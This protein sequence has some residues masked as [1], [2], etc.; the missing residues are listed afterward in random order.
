MGPPPRDPHPTPEEPAFMTVPTDELTAVLT[1]LRLLEDKD[2]IGEHTSWYNQCWDDGR[3]DEWVATFTGDGV[4]ELGGAPDTVGPAALHAMITA[5]ASVGFVHLTMNHRIEV[6]GDTATQHCAV[7]LGRRSAR[8]EPGS[9]QW[10][11]SGRYVDT[12]RRTPDGWRFARRVF[13]P[14]ASLRG[15]PQW[16]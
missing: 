15:L 8:R 10:V 11:T 3:L 14:D 5:M 12:L 7:L 1:R 9:S 6:D 16:W 2:A 4:F 13:A